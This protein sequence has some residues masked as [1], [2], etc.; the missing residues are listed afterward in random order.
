MRLLNPKYGQLDLG[1]LLLRLGIGIMFMLHGWPKIVGGESTWSWLGNQMKYFGINTWPVLWGLSAAVA[2]FVG[3]IFFALGLL[4]RPWT[5][6]LAFTMV[7]AA[8]YH[9]NTDERFMDAS[10]SIELLIVFLAM[11]II[12]PGRFS[13]DRLLFKK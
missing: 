2:E 7:V 6:I 11:A 10:H 8:V 3:G 12:G 9:L 4:F 1:L 13:I 5:I